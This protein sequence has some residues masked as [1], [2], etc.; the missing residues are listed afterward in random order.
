MGEDPWSPVCERP[1]GLQP[2]RRVDPLGVDGPTRGASRGRL[3]ERIAPGLYVPTGR[4]DVVEQRILEQSAR[5]PATGA[6]TG[7]G[8]LRWRGG[9]FFDGTWHGGRHQ[10]PVPLVLGRV[11]NLRRHPATHVSREQFAPSERVVVDGLPV[12]TVQRALFDE[13]RRTGSL[14]H[15]VQAVEMAAAA[16]LISVGLMASYVSHRPA[17]TG[18]PLVRKALGIAI[19]TSRS[20]RETWMRLVWL[21]CGYPPPLCNQPVYDR[22][23]RL[24][25]YPDLFDPVA[26]LV[27]EYDGADHKDR[28]RHRR[29]VAREEGFR[30]HGLEYF[31]VVAGDDDYVAAR[32]M[33]DARSRSKFLPPESCAWTLSPPAWVPTPESLDDYFLRLGLVDELTHT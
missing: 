17:W 13:M 28:D 31:A 2:A 16:R 5:L 15:A 9:A 33:S 27:G 18:V 23:G 25:G 12:A 19:D 30:N 22:D 7:W 10:L 20:P 24:L 3:W 21:W 29:D 14:L 4:P 26:G 8:A 11:A 6:V 32:R 1:P